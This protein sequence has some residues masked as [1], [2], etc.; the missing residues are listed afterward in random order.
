MLTIRNELTAIYRTL[1]VSGRTEAAVVA[2]EVALSLR[3]LAR[4]EAEDS[5]VVLIDLDAASGRAI[6][7]DTVGGFQP[8]DSLLIEKILAAKCSDRTKINNVSSQFVIA[9]FT[10]EDIDFF[11]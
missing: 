3:I 11:V 1:G 10:G 4:L 2:H 6:G 8:P 9:R 5:L 7:A